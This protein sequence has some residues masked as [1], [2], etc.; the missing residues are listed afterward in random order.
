MNEC[1]ESSPR[2]TDRMPWRHEE[3]KSLG[4]AYNGLCLRAAH[5]SDLVL[6]TKAVTVV[7]PLRSPW[8]LP[9]S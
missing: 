1:D 7:G 2:C 3:H 5:A 6:H 9:H 8:L 4:A